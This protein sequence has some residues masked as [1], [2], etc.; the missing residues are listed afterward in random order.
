MQQQDYH[1]SITAPVTAEEAFESI[2]NVPAWWAK[3]FEGS[4]NALHDIFTV[5]F[6]TTWVS[7]EIT[8]LIPGKRVVWY[9]TDCYLDFI[10]DKHEWTGTSVV[11]EVSTDGDST[12]I[13]MTHLGLVP[14]AE[15]FGQCQAGWDDHIK[16]SLVKY[17]TGHAGMPV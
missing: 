9:V 11:W 16:N 13:D 17:I 15:C 7:F 2:A 5:R 8:E 3:H 1:C 10:G 14:E 6:G 12:F 4:S